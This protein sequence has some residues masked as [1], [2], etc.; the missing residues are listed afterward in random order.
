MCA[1]ISVYWRDLPVA[2]VENHLLHGRK[3]VRSEGAEPEI[4]FLFRA[5]PRLLPAWHEGQLAIYAWGN[6]DRRSKLPVTG[7]AMLEDVEAGR[8]ADLRPEIVDIPACF[9]WDRGVWYQ[10]REGVR[11]ILVWDGEERACVYILTEKASHY[12]EVM[13]RNERMPV[14]IGRQ[15]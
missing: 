12:Y 9:A 2:L 13:T 8:W 1:G 11:G 10:V 4:Q 7:W 5:L 15:I 14:F 6:T 3:I